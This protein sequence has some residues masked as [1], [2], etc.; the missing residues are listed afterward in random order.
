MH[1]LASEEYGFRC[2]LQVALHRGQ[3]PISI[4]EIAQKEGLSRE[5]VGRLLHRLRLGGLVTSTRGASG[6]YRLARPADEVSVWEALTVLGGELLPEGFCDCHPGQ[7][8]E[9]VHITDCSVR[10]LWRKIEHTLREALSEV[11]LADLRRNEV[12]MAAWLD[13]PGVFLSGKVS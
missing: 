12:S 2:L 9:C 7:R 1:L 10:A 8:R 13:S 3:R 6:G 11:T 4:P 5:Y